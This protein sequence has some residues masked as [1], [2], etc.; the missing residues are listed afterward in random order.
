MK[1]LLHGEPSTPYVISSINTDGDAVMEKFLFTLGC[2]AG[3]TVTIIS[4]LHGNFVINANNARYSIDSD[5]AAAI[6]I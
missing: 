6:R 3:Q 2:Y 1:S 5:L 4:A